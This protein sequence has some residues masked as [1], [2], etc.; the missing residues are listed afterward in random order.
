[1]VAFELGES[2]SET[3]ET[4]THARILLRRKCMQLIAIQMLHLPKNLAALYHD[5]LNLR[6]LLCSWQ[7]NRLAVWRHHG[8][9]LN[10]YFLH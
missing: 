8:I 1:M 2:E 6:M 5:V 3:E 9:L 4:C 7:Q 10:R